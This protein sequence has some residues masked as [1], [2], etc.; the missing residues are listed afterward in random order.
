MPRKRK[1]NV[2]DSLDFDHEAD[3]RFIVDTSDDVRANILLTTAQ[4]AQRWHLKPD[5]IRKMRN[6]NSGPPFICMNRRRVLYRLFD[7]INFEA[8]RVAHSR[9]EAR[10]V[11][12]L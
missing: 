4:L 12:L 11:G 2:A 7:V 3:A 10:A 6:R 1:I 5:A 8:N 9:G